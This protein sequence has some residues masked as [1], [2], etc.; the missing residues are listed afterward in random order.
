MEPYYEKMAEYIKG[1]KTWDEKL[2]KERE[3]KWNNPEFVTKQETKLRL[4]R[5][6]VD[7]D[8]RINDYKNFNNLLQSSIELIDSVREVA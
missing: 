7:L 2:T 6:I 4:S 8:N 3:F 1:Y 5:E